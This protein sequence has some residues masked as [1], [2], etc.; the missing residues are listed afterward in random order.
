MEPEIGSLKTSTTEV[1]VIDGRSN[2]LAQA[3]S[4]QTI[5]MEGAL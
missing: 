3:S 1:N 4:A 2:I 5:E